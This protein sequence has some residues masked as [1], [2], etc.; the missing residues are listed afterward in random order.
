MTIPFYVVAPLSTVD[1]STASGH[2]IPIEERS[3]EEVTEIRGLRIAPRGIKARH[4]AFDVTPAKYI[5]GIVT[6]EVSLCPRILESLKDLVAHEQA[7]A[8]SSGS[9]STISETASA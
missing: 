6:I 3:M 5:T 1:L 4:P 8:A 9:V 2:R 7:P